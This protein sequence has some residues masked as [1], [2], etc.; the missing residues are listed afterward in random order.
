[1]LPLSRAIGLLFILFA[2]RC[3]CTTDTDYYNEDDYDMYYDYDNDNDTTTQT[4]TTISTSIPEVTTSFKR[5]E[6]KED[7]EYIEPVKFS[8][9]Y[10]DSPK[11]DYK[12]PK[13]CLCTNEFKFV[14]CS[15]NNLTQV[16]IDV[17]DI[18]TQLDL[19]NNLIEN[20]NNEDLSNFTNLKTIWLSNNKISNL[21]KEIFA[22]L[23]RLEHI[24]LANNNL[25][26]INADT[27]NEAIALKKLNLNN[28]N[29]VI[30]MDG[31][32]LNQSDLEELFLDNCNIESITD[33]TF[34][35]LI[36]LT[37]LDLNNNNFDEKI[38]TQA[39]VPLKNLAKLKLPKLEQD[40]VADLCKILTSI[41]LI[42][43]KN[44]DISCFELESGS[45]YDESTIRK[46]PETMQEDEEIKKEVENKE[47]NVE[48]PK[49]SAKER[50]PKANTA[51]TSTTMNP[52]NIT[53][54]NGH[55]SL[56]STSDTNEHK[57]EDGPYK[58]AISSQTINHILIGIII[59]A[60]VG[61]II[62]IICRR[63]ICGIKT[64][65][66]RTR[67][68]PPTDQVRPAEEIPLNKV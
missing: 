45:S 29:I 30:P 24:E 68:P 66:C 19:R 43:F 57:G 39:F 62:G 7:T 26:E 61:I 44:Y 37:I 6:M 64:K 38:N 53:D 48:K 54:T 14:N 41:D 20:L 47:Q 50:K 1:M 3:C 49:P 12:C 17:P 56:N 13:K 21:R 2:A 35:E 28:N 40:T 36:G 51:I 8:D 15:N 46:I 59:V 60:V 67:R 4:P 52:I 25:A 23:K 42:S 11:L 27:F 10:F 34:Q 9:L 31:V 58:V 63:D 55:E 33:D 22:G 16:P 65:C 32:F 5:K 18:V